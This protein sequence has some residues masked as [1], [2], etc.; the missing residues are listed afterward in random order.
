MIK[1]EGNKITI[2]GTNRQLLYEFAHI[3]NA[4]LRDKS[5]IVAATTVYFADKLENS[6]FN[7]DITHYAIEF[8]STIGE[9]QFDE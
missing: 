8:L 6:G 3:Y 9:G 5:E 7:P 1:L 2:D 4:F